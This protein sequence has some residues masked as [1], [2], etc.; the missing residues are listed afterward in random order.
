M[1]L[2]FKEAVSFFKTLP[3]S[4]RYPSFHPDYLASDASRVPNAVASFFIYQEGLDTFYF[5]FLLIPHEEKKDSFVVES[6]Y[7][8]GGP[9]LTNEKKDFIQRSYGNFRSW[10]REKNIV[11]EFIRFH[12]LLENW[13]HYDGPTF[14]N[15][16]TVWIDLTREFQY[17]QR[18]RTAIK[19]AEKHLTVQI[20]TRGESYDLFREVYLEGMKLIGAQEFYLFKKEYFDRLKKWEDVFSLFAYYEG[21]CVAAS[22]FLR[23]EKEMEY[24]LSACLEVGR[25][26]SASNL[27]IHRAAELGRNEGLS[28][29]HLGGGN[30]TESDNKLLFFKSGFSPLR[31]S[32]Y[33]GKKE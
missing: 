26:F 3:S 2:D 18:V 7:G 13:K 12:P 27:L 9:L 25:K 1:L 24:H 23:S 29:L 4:L 5:P 22:L 16:E 6:A 10:C 19:K 33:I 28:Y 15:R 11:R 32:F 17:E 30:T 21:K 14:L 31:S 20:D 8:Y